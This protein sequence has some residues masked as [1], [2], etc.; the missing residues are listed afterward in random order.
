MII[1]IKWLE[2]IM[3]KENIFI[4]HAINIGKKNI[5]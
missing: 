3:L 5:K 2:E 4:Q 1:S